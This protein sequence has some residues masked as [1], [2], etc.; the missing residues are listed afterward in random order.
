LSACASPPPISNSCGWEQL[1]VPDA[2]FET[3]WT[4]TEKA[5]V[6]EHNLNVAKFCP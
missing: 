5:Q 2:G 1:I 6:V 4:F 3:R